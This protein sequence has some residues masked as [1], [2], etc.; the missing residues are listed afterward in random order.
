[1]ADN[2]KRVLFVSSGMCPYLPEAPVSSIARYLPQGIQE[3]KREI[4]SFM[5]R[6]GFINERKNQLHEV[7]RLSG[8]NIIISRNSEFLQ[9]WC[10]DHRKFISS[11]LKMVMGKD[12]TSDYRKVCVGTGSIMW[13]HF[14][15]A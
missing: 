13:K 14:Y 8:M 10:S 4:R 15:K 9:E 7:I 12:R 2:I 3:R 11:S 6:Y 5:P 1:M